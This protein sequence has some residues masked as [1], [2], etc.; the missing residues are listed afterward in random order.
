[1]GQSLALTARHVGAALADDRL[2]AFRKTG[3]ILL[4]PRGPAY[5]T[6][7]LGRSPPAAQSNVLTQRTVEDKCLLRHQA[8]TA[9]DGA[10]LVITH[11]HAVDGQS[12]LGRRI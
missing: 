1:D 11:I 12:P 7:L 2:V 10:Q 9:T 8:D 3:D 4:Q 6:Q 5:L